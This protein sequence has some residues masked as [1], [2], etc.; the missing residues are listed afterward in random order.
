MKAN[1]ITLE[2]W[3]QKQEFYIVN[4][5][6][7]AIKRTLRFLSIK[8]IAWKT[9]I[10]AFRSPNYEGRNFSLLIVWDVMHISNTYLPF[11]NIFYKLIYF[12]RN[13]RRV[14]DAAKYL[15]LINSWR[16]K[17]IPKIYL[18]LKCNLNCPYCSN[19]I[20]YDQSN[21]GYSI[22]STDEWI[23]IINGLKSKTI[24][25]TGGEPSLYPNL[26][27]II[28]AVDKHF[29]IFTNLPLH[30]IKLL[31]S[32]NRPV[33]VFGSIHIYDGLDVRESV[34]KNLMVLETSKNLYYSAHMVDVES[35]RKVMADYVDFL[36]TNK[37]PVTINRNQIVDN[38]ACKGEF[39]KKVKCSY[40]EFYIGP[41]G[42][43]YIC[44]SKLVRKAK[45]GI[46]D[47]NVKNP[48]IICHEYGLCSP[49][50]EIAKVE[51]IA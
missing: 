3:S 26:Q 44:V 11:S 50:D 10:F 7:N 48:E 42:N 6:I 51:I 5:I 43:R 18:T 28:N 9:R 37:I 32:L 25:L 21:M 38:G 29:M 30:F 46:I 23:E 14:L 1:E 39:K 2:K 22:L 36:K 8:Y 33:S 49:C 24:I 41:D 31:N 12:R 19:G 47:Y 13:P 20:F 34:I 4:S 40:N 15:F 17:E 35:N 16:W 45:E 27:K